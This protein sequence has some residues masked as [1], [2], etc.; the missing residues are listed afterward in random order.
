MYSIWRLIGVGKTIYP[1]TDD[2]LRTDDT[3]RNRV[4]DGPQMG[5]SLFLEIEAKMASDLPI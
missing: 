4:D 5:R 1:E 3:F 2:P